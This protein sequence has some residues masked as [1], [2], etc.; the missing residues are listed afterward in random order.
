MILHEKISEKLPG[1]RERIK[2]LTKE[3]AD[4]VVDHVT[5]G[6]VV[7]GMRDI[8]S[9]FTDVSFVDPAHGILFRGMPIP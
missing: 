1:W 5:V 2:S 9:L 6:Q 4:V 8:K 7:G 3:H